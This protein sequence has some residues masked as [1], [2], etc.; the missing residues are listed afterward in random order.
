MIA[1]VVAWQMDPRALREFAETLKTESF[2]PWTLLAALA[3][4]GL[5]VWLV[6]REKRPKPRTD[7]LTL[8]A[9]G[10]GFSEPERHALLL[11]ARRAGLLHPAALLLSPANFDHAVQRARIAASDT[12]GQTLSA[13]RRRL[14]E[15]G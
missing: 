10:L 5:L 14:F 6:L 15:P 4:V 11:V 3:V 9:D 7:L 13:L 1:F 2:N 12:H 8:A